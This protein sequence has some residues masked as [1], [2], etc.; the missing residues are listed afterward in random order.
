M[1]LRED[2]IHETVAELPLRPALTVTPEVTIAQAI[3]LM[4]E[5]KLGCVFV[6]DAQGR[7]VGKFTERQ[8]VKLLCACVPLDEPVT[9]HMVV[10]PAESCVRKTDPVQKVLEAMRQ[11]RLRFICVVDDDGRVK[12]MTGQKGLMEYITERFPRQIKVQ[13]MESKLHMNAREGA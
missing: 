11:T 10:I 4:R 13:M 1:G 2:I 7:P 5:D 8:V 9:K 12:A 6:V 3:K